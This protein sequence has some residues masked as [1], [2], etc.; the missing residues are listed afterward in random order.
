[1]TCFAPMDRTISTLLVLHTPVTSAPNDLAICT[2][3]V[4]TP[5]P[6]PLIRTFCPDRIFPLSRRPCNAVSAATLTE[7]A[8]SNVTLEGFVA[9]ADSEVHAYSAKDP[10]HEPNTSS[11]GLNSV[12]FLPTA[13]TCPATSTPSCGFFGLR[14]PAIMRRKYGV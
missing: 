12:T 5:P 10:R 6:A 7:A 9:T 2:A 1:M 11:P 3:N 8:C 13:S 14:R 4:P